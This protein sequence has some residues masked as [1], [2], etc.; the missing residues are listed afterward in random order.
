MNERNNASRNLRIGALV[1]VSMIILMVFLFFIGS[2]QRLFSRKNDYRVE[3]ESVSGLAVGNP[4]RLSGVNVGTVQSIFLPRDP[5]QG[6]VKLDIAVE[7]RYAERIRMDSRARMKKLGLLAGDSYIEITPGSPDQRI[8]PPGSLIPSAKQTNVDALVASGEELADNM[9]EISHSL[10][11][12]L[13]RVDRGEGLIGELTQSP[14]SKQ[15]ITETFLVT[16][17]KTNAM[18]KQIESG[19]GLAGKL[20]YDEEYGEQL[21]GSLRTSVASL[22]SITGNV[23]TSFESN[24]GALPLLLND[25]EGRRRVVALMDNLQVT[26]QRLAT[27]SEALEKGEGLVPRLMND[28]AYADETLREFSAL[29]KQLSETARKLNEGEG[30]AGKLISDPAVYESINDILIGINESRMLRWLVRNRQEAGIETRYEQAQEGTG[31]PAP[32]PTPSPTP[33]PASTALESLALEAA[34]EVPD[35]GPVPA[36]SPAPTP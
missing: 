5:R 16:L 2:E 15:K 32:S 25:P 19:Q 17:N 11:N 30:T 22:E 13:G 33:L 14:E 12:I 8:L 20:I 9:V 36:P 6:G 4:V 31:I 23:R 29:V 24:T 10:K 28:R 3:F 27:F 35:I 26:T 34:E 7:K 1:G 21:S 18:L